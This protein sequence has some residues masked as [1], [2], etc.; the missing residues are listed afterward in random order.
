MVMISPLI[1]LVDKPDADK[2]EDQ[3][4]GR[5]SKLTVA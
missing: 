5:Q 2:V 3:S 4:G 1:R